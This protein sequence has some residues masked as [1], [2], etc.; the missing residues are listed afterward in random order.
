MNIHQNLILKNFLSYRFYKILNIKFLK[1]GL[2]PFLFKLLV[3]VVLNLM[4]LNFYIYKDRKIFLFAYFIGSY[5]EE[6][7]YIIIDF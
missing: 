1:N 7:Y 6:L 4:F 5:A 2:C 3:L